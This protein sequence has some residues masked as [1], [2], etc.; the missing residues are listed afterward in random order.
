MKV[1]ELIRQL[2]Q[3]NPNDDICALYWEK[4]SYDY[5]DD[6]ENVL[7]TEA[8]AEIC[9]EFDEWDDAGVELSEWIAD[10][11]IEKTEVRV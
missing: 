6:D 1:S 2:N 9:H 8:W 10:A 4:P 11:V 7:T 3:L 5:D